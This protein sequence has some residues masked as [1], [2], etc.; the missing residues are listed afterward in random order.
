[1]TCMQMEKCGV[2][3]FLVVERGNKLLIIVT[4]ENNT[5]VLDMFTTQQKI[6][7]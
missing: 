5:Q 7:S 4:L 6:N 2:K 3:I 1:M